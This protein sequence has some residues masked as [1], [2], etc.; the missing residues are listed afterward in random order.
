MP[1]TRTDPRENASVP[2]GRNM[3]QWLESLGF[4]HDDEMEAYYIYVKAGEKLFPLACHD[5]TGKWTYGSHELPTKTRT[6]NAGVRF[7]ACKPKWLAT[8]TSWI[9]HGHLPRNL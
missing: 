3:A 1:D 2:T 8:S 7:A 9:N 4:T 5:A 6:A